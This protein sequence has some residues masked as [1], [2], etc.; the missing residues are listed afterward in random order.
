MKTATAAGKVTAS[1]MIVV[2]IWPKRSFIT[3]SASDARP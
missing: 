3:A 1:T 2:R